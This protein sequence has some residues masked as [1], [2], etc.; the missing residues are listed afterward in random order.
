MMQISG[1]LIPWIS[2]LFDDVLAHITAVEESEHGA[3]IYG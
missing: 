2:S 1:P 3:E